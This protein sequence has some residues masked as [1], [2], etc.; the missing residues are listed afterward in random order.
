M[1]G[2]QIGCVNRVPARAEQDGRLRPRLRWDYVQRPGGWSWPASLSV[3]PPPGGPARDSERPDP[4]QT[5]RGKALELNPQS[6]FSASPPGAS[7]TKQAGKAAVA[8]KAVLSVAVRIRCEFFL[9]ALDPTGDQT[10]ARSLPSFVPQLDLPARRETRK[11]GSLLPVAG[12]PSRPHERPVPHRPAASALV[13]PSRSGSLSGSDGCCC[14]RGLCPA[15]SA[16][17]VPSFYF[18]LSNAYFPA[19]ERAFKTLPS[20]QHNTK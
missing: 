19:F 12:P 3:P 2:L 8:L 13:R 9:W 1:E 4:G 6:G 14:G 20:F 10:L 7:A 5:G 18:F 16:H 15:C 17:P 11:E